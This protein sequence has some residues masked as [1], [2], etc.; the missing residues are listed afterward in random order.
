MAAYKSYRLHFT[1][2]TGNSN[3]YVTINEWQMFES[4]DGSSPNVLTG[5]VASASGSYTAST[6]PI[7]A[8]DGSPN[9]YWESSHG[10]PHWLQYDL[11][12]AVE[13]RSI[14]IL[15]KQYNGERPRSFEL[16][17]SND[18]DT[19]E[20]VCLFIDVFSDG[21]TSDQQNN[22][23]RSS[24]VRELSGISLLDDGTTVELI[25]IFE[26]DTGKLIHSFVPGIDGHWKVVLANAKDVLV[27]QYPPVGYRPQADGPIVVRSKW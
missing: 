4:E 13:A 18:G 2:N 6:Q 14:Y 7:G 11:P 15:S 17:G 27:V 24:I 1:E 16:L 3:G 25:R 19:W 5:G 22:V 26:W 9:T 23:L 20:S 21:S 8:F 10:L 12:Q